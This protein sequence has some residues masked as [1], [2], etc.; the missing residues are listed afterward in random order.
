MG[1]SYLAEGIAERPATFQLFCR[2][3]P[4]GWG[5]LV[6]AG[7]DDALAYLERLRFTPDELAYL[8]TTGLFSAAFLDRLARLRFTRRRAGDAGGDGL[9]PGRAGA[10]GDGAAARGAARRDGR[11][12]RASTSSR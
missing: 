12:E 6:A 7:L 5:Y 1:E 8:E 3:L 10:R 11:P 2:H 4:P 9:L